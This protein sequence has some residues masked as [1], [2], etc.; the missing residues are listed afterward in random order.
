MHKRPP[1]AHWKSKSLPGEAVDGL[2]C[3][4]KRHKPKTV[5]EGANFLPTVSGGQVKEDL[6]LLQMDLKEK[7]SPPSNTHTHTHKGRKLK[8]PNPS[9]TLRSVNRVPAPHTVAEYKRPPSVRAITTGDR[10]ICVAVRPTGL[11]EA[12]TRL[13]HMCSRRRTTYM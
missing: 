11:D 13:A 9:C 12:V 3:I 2:I 8:R 10:S 4:L 6:T 7:C 1:W 5:K